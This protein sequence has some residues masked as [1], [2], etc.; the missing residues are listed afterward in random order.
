VSALQLVEAVS[1][2]LLRL[3]TWQ[4]L[5]NPPFPLPLA[6][7]E[8]RRWA[9]FL[10]APGEQAAQMSPEI[11]AIL[12][13][14]MP[15]YLQG[16]DSFSQGVEPLAKAPL[17]LIHGDLSPANLCIDGHQ[18]TGILDWGNLAWGDVC[19]DWAK[20]LLPTLTPGDSA[21]LLR[22][23]QIYSDAGLDTTDF[24][25]RFWGCALRVMLVRL[26]LPVYGDPTYQLQKSWAVLAA[27][28]ASQSP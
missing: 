17:G 6:D 2:V 26:T 21:P 4:P 14:H 19:L 28:L 9:E 12:Q 8:P 13:Q 10:A 23:Q 5:A 24:E 22:L 27:R 1:P 20:L 25:A 18:V 11:A 15:L 7:R 3:H 16:L